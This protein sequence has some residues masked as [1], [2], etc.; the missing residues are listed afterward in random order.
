MALI[1]C[2]ECRKE[3]SDKASTC[4]GCGAPV[5]QGH[6]IFCKKCGKKISDQAS[7]CPHCGVG[8]EQKKWAQMKEK[9]WAPAP[10]SKKTGCFGGCFGVIVII[11]VLFIAMVGSFFDRPTRKNSTS[12]PAT[13]KNS[14]S[15]PATTK[16]IFSAGKIADAKRIFAAARQDCNIF[17]EGPHLVVEMRIH[18]P[19]SYQRLQYIKA[20]A[21]ADMILHGS[22]RNIYFEGPEGRIGQA[23]TLNGI[24]LTN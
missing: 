6:I 15:T 7:N 23:D 21:N 4:P 2:K 22:A 5:K 9:K 8:V 19:D 1:F 11:F 3:I 17:E 14:V 20:I 16:K 18:M 13:T 24:R 12:T 10:A